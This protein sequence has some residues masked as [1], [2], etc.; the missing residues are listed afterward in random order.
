M[1]SPN[2]EYA[3]ILKGT[4]IVFISRIPT[5]EELGTFGHVVIA[6]HEPW[7]PKNIKLGEVTSVQS[8]LVS[9]RL[10][11]G[12][13]AY[14]N[15]ECDEAILHGMQLVLV[16]FNNMI[17]DQRRVSA[18][19]MAQ[20]QIHIPDSRSFISTKI[21]SKVTAGLLAKRFGIGIYQE[22][23]TLKVAD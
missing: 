22:R 2:P 15:P 21:H 23:A 1:F 10:D 5:K 20:S 17:S 9:I 16:G 18:I 7:E 3:L 4:N 13:H 19:T 12:S 14:L 11:S 6:S 8:G